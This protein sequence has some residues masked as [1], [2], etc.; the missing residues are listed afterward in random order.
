MLFTIY[1][2]LLWYLKFEEKP[3]GEE[4]IFQQIFKD[5]KERLIGWQKFKHDFRARSIYRFCSVRF[6]FFFFKNFFAVSRQR[7]RLCVSIIFHDFEYRRKWQI[8][9]FIF[10]PLLSRNDSEVNFLL[11]FQT[12]SIVRERWKTF[13]HMVLIW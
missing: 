12:I 6:F 13:Y 10:F 2:L 11:D 9:L 8:K 7:W 1:W 3:I 4:P 5:K